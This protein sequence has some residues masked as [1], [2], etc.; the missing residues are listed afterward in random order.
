MGYEKRIVAGLG[1]LEDW[2]AFT[3]A[4][5]I[6]LKNAEDS[7]LIADQLDR[8]VPAQN[9]ANLAWQVRSFFLDNIKKP[10]WLSAWKIEKRGMQA[11]LIWESLA[12]ALTGVLVLLVSCFNYIT[13]S[14]GAAP[15]RPQAKRDWHS[16]DGGRRKK[17]A[18]LAVPHRKPHP[19]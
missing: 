14:L 15:C 2:G 13:I 17:A 9:A 7:Q 6:Q 11:P 12:F 4:T 10:D 8:H 19:L 5:F 16:K 18:C 3:E 1:R